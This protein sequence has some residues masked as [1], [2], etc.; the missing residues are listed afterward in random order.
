MG[1]ST[2]ESQHLRF[3][4]ECSDEF[5][6]IPTYGTIPSVKAVFDSTIIQD[7]LVANNI[8]GDPVKV[9]NTI[10]LIDRYFFHLCPHHI[11]IF[12]L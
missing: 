9:Y 1:V 4:Y 2:R 7:A 8:K 10:Y 6:L 3:L 12:C 11:L 5:S